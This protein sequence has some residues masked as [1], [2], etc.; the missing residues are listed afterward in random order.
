MAKKKQKKIGRINPILY[1]F[2][3]H[4]L[5]P[6][7]RIRYGLTVDNRAI[8][9][10]RG[11][12]LVIAPHTS[13]KDHWLVSMGIYPL[14][15]TFVLSE[16]FV[17]SPKLR[18]ILRL[19]HIITKKMFCPDVSTIMNVLRAK[20]EGNN[21]VLFPEG[22]LASN[23]R[24]GRVADGT[25]TLVKKLG[26][27][28][29]VVTANGASLTF[30]KWA[31]KP[32]RGKI[33]VVTERLFTAEETAA[34]SEDELTARMQAVITH[35]DAAAMDGVRYRSAAP[36]EGL[37]GILYR[38]PECER[39]FTMQTEGD[40]IF[41]TECGFSATLDETF[42]LHGCRF[43]RI[44]D[45]YDWQS[46]LVDP[47]AERLETDAVIGTADADGNMNKN[48]GTAHITMDKD[49]FT[50]NGTVFGEPLVFARRTAGIVAFPLAVGAEFDV[51]YNNKLYFIYP[52]TPDSRAAV[53]WVAYLDRL[54][55][56]LRAQA[57]REKIAEIAERS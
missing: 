52:Q 27:D 23:G 55:E 34:L 39:E 26:V 44:L 6:I 40:R 47:T 11:P 54:T 1:W 12:I 7:Y 13:N 10:V 15:P 43:E 18:P 20:R 35:D 14:R 25:A 2:V 5:H 50:F 16:H 48:A 8:R 31:K 19:A 28:V 21:I 29:Y 9:G 3:Y 24:T 38:C 37:D 4:V 49:T 42:R 41:C 33:R 53:K 17:T 30:P 45:W 32:H 51:Y 36:A 57:E 56:E 22:R 46:D